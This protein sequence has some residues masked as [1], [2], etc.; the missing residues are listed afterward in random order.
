MSVCLK[1]NVV[2][3]D[4]FVL[5]PSD[6]SLFTFVFVQAQKILSQYKSYPLLQLSKLHWDFVFVHV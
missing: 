3:R 5:L 1:L 4:Y 2:L 6:N